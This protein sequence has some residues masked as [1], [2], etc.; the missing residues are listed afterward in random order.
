MLSLVDIINKEYLWDVDEEDLWVNAVK[1]L[2]AGTGDV[3]ST[4]LT[5]Q[6][7]K[8]YNTSSTNF[9]GI[10]VQIS[11][12]SSGNVEITK[13]FNDSPAFKAGLLAGDQILTCDDES[14]IGKSTEYAV[15]ILRGPKG[16]K[17]KLVILRQGEADLLEFT[18]TRDTIIN[19]YV[20]KSM[21]DDKIGYIHVSEFGLN[22]S[23][24]FDSAV[25][26]LSDAG[27]KAL[28]LDL[29]QNPG[30]NVMDAINI[31]DALLPSAE[32]IYTLD[33]AGNREDYV[34]DSYFIDVP[35]VVLV[36]ASSASASEIVAGALQDNARAKIIGAKTFG[37]GIIQYIKPLSD[38]SMYKLTYQE[39]YVP[40]GK[41]IH[42]EGITPDILVELPE[43]Q[44][45]KLVELIP[46]GEDTQ[47]Q[48]AIEELQF[49]L[50]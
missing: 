15:T 20:D 29:R 14:L 40:S 9:D 4:Y 7:F 42:G 41:K 35:L 49:M 48:R 33:K 47:L 37:K 17:A 43:S 24:S 6:E 28:I 45:K 36:D 21:L 22:S 34:S 5:K 30:G 19:K 26:E 18:V 11:N 3:Y 23:F 25:K 8:D 27:M 13:V 32:I 44:Q 2:V 38:G 46:A 50:R 39:Y 10:G 12:N 31:A 16:T 1:G